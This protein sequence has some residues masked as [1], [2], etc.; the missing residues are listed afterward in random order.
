MTPRLAAAFVVTVSACG[1]PGLPEPV[2]GASAGTSP[3][4]STAQGAPTGDGVVTPVPRGEEI[5]I[6]PGRLTVDE[7]G[8]CVAMGYA[9]PRRG[10]PPP[11]CPQGAICNPPPPLRVPQPCPTIPASAQVSTF[12]N[13]SMTPQCDATWAIPCDDPTRCSSTMTVSGTC[14]QVL[15]LR[16]GTTAIAGVVPTVVETTVLGRGSCLSSTKRGPSCPDG[17]GCPAAPFNCPAT[18]GDALVL[19]KD[20]MCVAF[21]SSCEAGACQQTTMMGP[22]QDFPPAL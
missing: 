20:S 8:T 4:G 17:V 14:R 16:E 12:A 13:G 15:P 19:R 21:W 2:P 3:P 6:L 5:Q 18:P 7:D 11:T 22:C 10:E 1:R 9:V